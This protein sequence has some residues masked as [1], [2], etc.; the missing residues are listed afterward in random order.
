M[1]KKGWSTFQ[2]ASYRVHHIE[3]FFS[4]LRKCLNCFLEIKFHS[5]LI[6]LSVFIYIYR[7]SHSTREHWSIT[8]SCSDTFPIPWFNTPINWLLNSVSICKKELEEAST[9]SLTWFLAEQILRN[10]QKNGIGNLPLSNYSTIF[11]CN[12]TY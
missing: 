5:Q 8:E 9:S 6:S 7:K 11:F 4:H 3:C 12:L 2:S 10:I 1:R